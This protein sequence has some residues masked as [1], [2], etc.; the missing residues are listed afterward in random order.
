[1]RY[2]RKAVREWGFDY[3]MLDFNWS[4]FSNADPTRTMAEVI[5][6]R[7][8]AI[9]RV[10]GRGT[11]IE[12]CMCPLGPVVGLADGLR[13]APDFR[14]GKEDT[15]IP[16]FAATAAIH[17]RVF[18]LD[19]EFVD[20][21][22]R[23]FVWGSGQVQ[24]PLAGVEAYV[25]L[26]ALTG[27]SILG[28]GNMRGT[29]AERYALLTKALPVYGRPAHSLIRFTSKPKGYAPS[30]KPVNKRSRTQYPQNT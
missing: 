7:F 8:A 22:L 17:G 27:F 1:M 4:D 28:G 6:D 11:F 16:N 30:K 5:R 13:V 29:S 2:Y 9:R 10:A 25:S 21:A 23:P 14:G 18:Q 19:S 3:L 15:L 24:A 20:V 12:A 26:L